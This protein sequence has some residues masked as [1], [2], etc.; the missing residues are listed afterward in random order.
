MAT[1]FLMIGGPLHRERLTGK[2]L[3]EKMPDYRY[4]YAGYNAASGGRGKPSAVYIHNELFVEAQVVKLV[5]HVSLR[6]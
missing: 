3:A 4:H 5:E 6:G 2:E 1:K